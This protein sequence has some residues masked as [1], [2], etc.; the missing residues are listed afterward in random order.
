[1]AEAFAK[2]RVA[3]SIAGSR[4]APDQT[5]RLRALDPRRRRLL[6]L[7]RVTDTATAA[8][9]AQ[10]L[11]LSHRTVVALARTLVADGFLALADPS[12][13]NRAY[14]LGAAYADLVARN[15]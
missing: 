4:A 15:G 3:A 1:M 12:R 9:M 5:Q 11:G 6:E 13:K 14:R 7:F 2:V 8:N 10:H